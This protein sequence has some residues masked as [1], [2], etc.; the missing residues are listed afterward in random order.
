MA[1]ENSPT[2]ILARSTATLQTDS[3]RQNLGLSAVVTLIEFTNLV[4]VDSIS[5]FSY[6]PIEEEDNERI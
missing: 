2:A 5:V 6:P 1:V 3:H 4:L